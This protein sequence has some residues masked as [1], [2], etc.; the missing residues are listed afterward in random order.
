[1]VLHKPCPPGGTVFQGDGCRDCHAYCG[2]HLPDSKGFS[3]SYFKAGYQTKK[4]CYIQT[5][6]EL[7]LLLIGFLPE[8]HF[9][10]PPIPVIIPTIC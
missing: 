6:R 1:M 10:Y 5:N 4:Y 8:C 9:P 2:F 3:H 7:P